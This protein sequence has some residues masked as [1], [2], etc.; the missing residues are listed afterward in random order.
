VTNSK[1]GFI[2]IGFGA[3]ALLLALLHFW[4]GPFSPRPSLEQTV[5]EKAA[6]I[7][8]ITIAALRGE[9]AS[10]P[11]PRGSMDADKITNIVTALLGGIA[12]IFG[13]IGFANKE[14]IR[15]SSGAAILGGGAIAFQFTVLAIGIIV[16]VILVMYVLS[17]IG[18]S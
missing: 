4:A 13:V 16:V 9:K 2:G 14:P 10:I 7:K 3:V 18:F 15:V 6:S 1:F 17:Q 11:E 12:I 5:A 8:N